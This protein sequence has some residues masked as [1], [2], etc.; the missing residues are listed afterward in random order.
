[1]KCS[2]ITV[3]V[4]ASKPAI[5]VGPLVGIAKHGISL[6]KIKKVLETETDEEWIKKTKANA[7]KK[8][9]IIFYGEVSEPIEETP[10][11]FWSSQLKLGRARVM[12]QQVGDINLET[13]VYK[14]NLAFFNERIIKY[15]GDAGLCKTIMD[16]DI[17]RVW[18]PEREGYVRVQLGDT[19]AKVRENLHCC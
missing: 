17:I 12:E 10:E 4:N 14:S 15:C 11:E 18:L 3:K 16:T 6:K 2:G 5:L 8:T 9:G 13:V 7:M 1:M 19:W